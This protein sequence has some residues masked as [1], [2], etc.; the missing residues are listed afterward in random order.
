MPNFNDAT[1]TRLF[2]SQL[3]STVE[4]DTPNA[5][6]M[7]DFCANIELA[8][9]TA[10]ESEGYTVTWGCTDITRGVAAPS[11]IP[12]APLSGVGSFD[13]AP[14]TKDPSGL[15]WV[16]EGQSTITRPGAGGQGHLYQ[17]SATLVTGNGQVASYSLSDPFLVL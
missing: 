14:W 5:P 16:Y 6:N 8:A 3:N 10:L 7:G 1:V 12:A 15:F 11:L 2:V 13:V 4:D 17:Y 9:G